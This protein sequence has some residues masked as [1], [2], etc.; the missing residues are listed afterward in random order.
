MKITK[1]IIAATTVA[2]LSGFYSQAQTLSESIARGQEVY[3]NECVTCHMDN[4]E[5]ISGA[6]PPLANSDYFKDDIA[7]AVN[8]IRNGLEGE[9][10]VNGTTYYGVMDP[11]D[12]TDQEIADVLNYIQNSWG[13]KAK[14]LDAKDIAKMN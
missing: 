8:A 7:K 10:T 12:L 11:V 13:G 14:A 1:K 4:G 2:C 3:L 6:F 9:L 5:G